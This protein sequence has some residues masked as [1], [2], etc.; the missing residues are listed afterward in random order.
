M[1]LDTT[2]SDRQSIEI[3]GHTSAD[4]YEMDFECHLKRIRIEFGGEVIVDST[5][6]MVLRE[7]QHLPTFYFPRS[8]IRMDLLHPTDHITHCPY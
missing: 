3:Q 5:Q 6:A 7:T 8:D 2:A 1:T 4:T